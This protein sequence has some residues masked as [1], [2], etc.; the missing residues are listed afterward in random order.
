MGMI[1]SYPANG[2]RLALMS[3]LVSTPCQLV[4]SGPMRYEFPSV[5]PPP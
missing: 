4:S 3:M 5:V 1:N 2:A